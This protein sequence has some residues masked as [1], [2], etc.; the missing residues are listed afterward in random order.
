MAQKWTLENNV[1]DFVKS[2]LT[3]L[4]LKNGN[5]H[6]HFDSNVFNEE[7][8]MS[9]SLKNA[10]QGSAKTQN[11]TNFGK[12]DFHLEN[13]K[14]LSQVIPVVIENKLG[15][16]NLVNE[17]KAGVKFDDKSISSFAVN[18]ALHYA[19]NILNSGSNYKEVI[20]IGTAGDDE[21]N[22]AIEGV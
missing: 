12:P 21:N 7:S 5:G 3:K 1:N 11:K 2:Q 6:N 9:D 19:R 16:K 20:A 15:T 14:H 8:K 13:R 22:C 18:G 10:L 4:G 17:T